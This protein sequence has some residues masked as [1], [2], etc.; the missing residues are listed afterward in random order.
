MRGKPKRHALRALILRSPRTPRPRPSS[1]R[2]AARG[3]GDRLGQPADRLSVPARLATPRRVNKPS[4]SGGILPYRPRPPPKPRDLANALP[5][6]LNRWLFAA[7]SAELLVPVFV[8]PEPL[9]PEPLLLVPLPLL[10]P[11]SRRSCWKSTP[12]SCRWLSFPCSSWRG[13]TELKQSPLR[14]LGQ[15]AEAGGTAQEPVP[16]GRALRLR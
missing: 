11:S 16:T 14:M 3:R 13:S 4:K 9:V 2:A 6:L 15:A 5:K 10:C 1:E 8:D 12:C 7:C